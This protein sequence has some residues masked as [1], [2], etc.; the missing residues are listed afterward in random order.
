MQPTKSF[1]FRILVFIVYC[2][3]SIT[4]R[5]IKLLQEHTCIDWQC[6][7]LI[8]AY[9][10]VVLMRLYWRTPCGSARTEDTLR[11]SCVSPRRTCADWSA[12]TP[13]P[14][15]WRQASSP[16]ACCRRSGPAECHL[17]TDTCSTTTPLRQPCNVEHSPRTSAPPI[18][19]PN[20]HLA[21]NP[22]LTIIS[23]ALFLINPTTVVFCF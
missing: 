6:M 2:F 14:A 9:T 16:W 22:N 15:R 10:A 12:C 1:V 4:W 8:V 23:L 19:N 3:F 11:T 20:H 17:S 5:W 7:I 13:S 18:H 21:I